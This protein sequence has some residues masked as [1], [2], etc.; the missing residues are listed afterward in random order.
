M[1]LA[2]RTIKRESFGRWIYIYA[3]SVLAHVV[4]FLLLVSGAGAAVDSAPLILELSLDSSAPIVETSFDSSSGPAGDGG[5][6]EVAAVAGDGQPRSPSD[7][8]GSGSIP[9]Q[10]S[11][12]SVPGIA[13]NSNIESGILASSVQ[14]ERAVFLTD[15]DAP[16]DALAAAPPRRGIAGHT[17]DPNAA[18]PFNFDRVAS[19]M[20]TQNPM[21]LAGLPEYPRAC[22]RG[23]CRSGRPCESTS[24]WKIWVQAEGG[25]PSKIHCLD[26]MECELQ[27][28]SIRKYFSAQQ[29]PR[30]SVPTAYMFTV[31]M[32]I[33]YYDEK[34]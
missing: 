29:F 34:R 32:M 19:A 21:L 10:S 8:L 28:A 13:M 1:R 30:T 22:R 12:S 17:V 11:S 31:P 18:A 3:I 4:A 26:P 20:A 27:N 14:S 2:V 9:G 25:V 5:S 7:L 16:L 6:R 23:L 24:V 15:G 33:V